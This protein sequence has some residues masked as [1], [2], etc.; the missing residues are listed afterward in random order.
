MFLHHAVVMNWLESITLASY[1]LALAY[2]WGST[3]VPVL[4]SMLSTYIL[5]DCPSLKSIWQILQ[6]FLFSAARLIFSSKC[7]HITPLFHQL[8]WLKASEQ[9]A[10]KQAVLVYKC[11]YGP[12][13]HTLLT[14][15]VR[16]QMSRRVSTCSR[17][18]CYSYP[19]SS[20]SAAVH[21]Y[22]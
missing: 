4:L 12:H 11:L 2:R 6:G 21:E 17:I 18:S 22:K 5:V 1:T 10:F 13:L 15:F 20:L 8:H 14:S 19:G 16:S 3:N 7:Q 9:I